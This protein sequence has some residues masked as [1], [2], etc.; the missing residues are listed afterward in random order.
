VKVETNGTGNM[1]PSQETK[2][3]KEGVS[4]HV[5][6]RKNGQSIRGVNFGQSMKWNEL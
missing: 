4:D 6:G 5:P 2:G 3:K 1:A